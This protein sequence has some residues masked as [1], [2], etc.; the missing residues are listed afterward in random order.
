M[1][2]RNDALSEFGFAAAAFSVLTFTLLVILRRGAELAGY[3]PNLG[4]MLVLSAA[5]IVVLMLSADRAH[6]WVSGGSALFMAGVAATAAL[7]FRKIPDYGFDAQSYHLPSVLRLLNGWKPMIEPTDLTLSNHY[8]S[9]M[10]TIL[11]GIDSIFGFE[12]GRAIG[13]IVMLAAGGVVWTMLHRVGLAAVPRALVTVLLVA[14]PVAVSEMFTAYAD[15]VLYELTLILICSLLMLLEDRRLATTMLACASTILVVNTKLAGLLFAPLA[16]A[17]WGLLL[18]LRFGSALVLMRDRR[19]QVAM[20]VAAS[21]LAVGFVGWRPYVINFLEHHRLVYPP[22]DEL[23]YKPGTGNQLPTNL[24]TAGTMVKLA[25]LFFA[26]TDI[27]GGPVNFKVPGTF[28]RQELRMST[29]TRNGGF[30]PFFGAA[31]LV[32]LAALGWATIRRT[33]SRTLDRHGIE[34]LLGLT[35]FGFVTT[36]LFPGAMVGSPCPT[37]VGD[38]DRCRMPRLHAAAQPVCSVMRD[39]LHGVVRA[40]CGDCRK[41]R[42]TR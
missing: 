19:S 15:G 8:P 23:G 38:S 28:T 4:V 34:V 40:Q 30:G 7:G 3:A 31:T 24:S 32:A 22:P 18:L 37:G 36:I 35:A 42:R 29:D 13:P 6:R 5:V 17:T 12:S 25:A 27:D 21:V 10:W 39:S 33:S 41:L 14:N 11:A 26:R 20:L 9:G 2:K 16:L 1:S